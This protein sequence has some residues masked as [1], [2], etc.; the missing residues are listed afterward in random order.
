[1]RV[2]L[3]FEPGLD[4]VF[5]HV[6]G[7]ARHLLARE[8][9][10][11]LAYSSRRS[12]D[13]LRKL[14]ADAR[15]AGAKLLDLQ[16][17]NALGLADVRAGLA[18]SRLV[19]DFAPDVIHAHSSKAGGLVRLLP[20]RRRLGRAVLYTPH[21]YFRMYAPRSPAARLFHLAERWLGRVG[22][23]VNCSETEAKF[24]R[25][26]VGIP[27]SRQVIIENGVDCARFAPAT[28]EQRARGRQEYGIPEGAFVVGTLGRFSQ[29]KD[30][31]TLY[32]ALRLAK[33]N[34]P[35][36]HFLHLGQG[37][38]LPEIERFV[39]E[40]RMDEWV[41]HVPYM[42]DTASFYRPLDA[43]ILTSRAEGLPY[44]LLEAMAS[45]LPLVLSACPGIS[46]MRHAGLSHAEWS[47]PG[48]PGAF[49]AAM[50]QLA[51]SV[52]PELSPNHREITI[53][54]FSEENCHRR[55]LQLYTESLS[56]RHGA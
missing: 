54:A 37:E 33:R 15:D 26:H 19:R 55:I 4:G 5:R 27:R 49:A 50:A 12:A 9:P 24:A 32:E 44:A 14:C 40:H 45:N 8:I 53:R 56:D 23:T 39:A 51:A 43:F 30:P 48:D 41:R 21:A 10:L 42:A 28:P 17:G 6:D 46:D 38:L 52:R 11:A 34:L 47:D 35:Q 13:G 18:L 20:N 29:Q 3:V 31:Q 7:L 36:L 1:M 22:G 2:L 25:E 16:V